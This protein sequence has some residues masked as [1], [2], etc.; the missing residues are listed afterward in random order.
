MMLQ[1]GSKSEDDKQITSNLYV[2]YIMPQWNQF[3][4]RFPE[5]APIY[6]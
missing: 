1:M 6:N 2:F 3:G 4:Q 5:W